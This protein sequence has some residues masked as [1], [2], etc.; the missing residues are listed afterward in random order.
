MDFLPRKVTM[1][2]FVDLL[3][4]HLDP[5]NDLDLNDSAV[6]DR[7]SRSIA[8]AV[9]SHQLDDIAI[10]GEIVRILSNWSN[11][12]IYKLTRFGGYDWLDCEASKA[13]LRDIVTRVQ[14]YIRIRRKVGPLPPDDWLS[15]D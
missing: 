5:D 7:E 15:K 12:E 13:I 9:Y 6:L 2:S 10:E 8:E 11:D 14:M 3:N 1:T 4:M